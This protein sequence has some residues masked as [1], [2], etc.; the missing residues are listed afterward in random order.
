MPRDSYIK[1]RVVSTDLRKLEEYCRQVKETMEAAGRR[2]KGPIPLPTKRLIIPV[3]RSPCGQGS[4]TWD[5][6]ELRIHRR[7][8]EVDVVD[9]KIFARI[10]RIRPPEGV[11]V[12]IKIPKIRPKS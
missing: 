6:W 3:R 4:E 8:L 1:I 5:K 7:L 12:D 9:P 2:V 11:Y 10:T